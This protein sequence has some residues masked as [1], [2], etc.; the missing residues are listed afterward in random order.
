M[1]HTAHHLH[2]SYGLKHMK[3]DTPTPPPTPAPSSHIHHQCFQNSHAPTQTHAH[4]SSHLLS[5]IFS[6]SVALQ[7]IL[8]TCINLCVAMTAVLKITAIISTKTKTL[9]PLGRERETEREEKEWHMCFMFVSDRGRVVS[10][11]FLHINYY[12]LCSMCICFLE[13]GT[14]YAWVP[15]LHVMKP[16]LRPSYEY[17][18]LLI[19]AGGLNDPFVEVHSFSKPTCT[20]PTYVYVCVFVLD[21]EWIALHC[22][23]ERR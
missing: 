16:R 17:V 10:R 2:S 13:G 19:S 14:V 4:L 20:V 5:P 6:L 21:S 23:R 15:W 11:F 7:Q 8:S 9:Q 1:S 12:V 18:M 3:K 22:V